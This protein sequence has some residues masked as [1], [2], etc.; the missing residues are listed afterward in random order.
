MTGCWVSDLSLLSYRSQPATRIN[1]SNLIPA[2]PIRLQTDFA[3]LFALQTNIITGV[4]IKVWFCFVIAYKIRALTLYMPYSLVLFFASQ[5][6]DCRSRCVCNVIVRAPDA[7]SLNKPLSPPSV[8]RYAV[9]TGITGHTLPVPILC[10]DMLKWDPP[11]RR[12]Y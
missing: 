9:R 4:G 1:Q 2:P 8:Y 11:L 7:R 5:L 12:M 6:Y 10:L 3:R